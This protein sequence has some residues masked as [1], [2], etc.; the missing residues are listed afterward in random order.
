[1]NLFVFDQKTR[2]VVIARDF[3]IYVAFLVPLTLLTFVVWRILLRQAKQKREKKDEG[4]ELR[5]RVR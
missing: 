5:L 3:W 4:S 1:M 2:H